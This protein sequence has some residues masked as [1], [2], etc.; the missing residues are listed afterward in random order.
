VTTRNA[1]DEPFSHSQVSE[2]GF[3][4]QHTVSSPFRIEC[5]SRV[6]WCSAC[7]H[8]KVAIVWTLDYRGLRTYLG[9]SLLHSL[10]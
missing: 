10:H 1:S 7:W 9:N 8:V 4:H 3:D 2:D 6:A 5:L